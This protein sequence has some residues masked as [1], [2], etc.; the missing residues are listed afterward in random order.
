MSLST[1]FLYCLI[2][3]TSRL[4]GGNT[5]NGTVGAWK[6]CELLLLLRQSQ[7][8]EEIGTWRKDDWTWRKDNWNVAKRWLE[9]GEKTIAPVWQNDSAQ[10][11]LSLRPF[12]VVIWALWRRHLGVVGKV[13]G[14]LTDVKNWR[15]KLRQNCSKMSGKQACRLTRWTMRTQRIIYGD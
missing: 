15:K 4:D 6:R 3:V 5:G 12:D 11:G 2:Q 7:S 10:M 1:L 9:R 8:K 13:A 14:C